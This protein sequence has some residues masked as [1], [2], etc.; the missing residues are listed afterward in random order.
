MMTTTVGAARAGLHGMQSADISHAI[1]P[2]ECEPTVSLL[3][4]FSIVW[5]KVMLFMRLEIALGQLHQVLV[6]AEFCGQRYKQEKG[7]PMGIN[8]AVF[9]ADYFLFQYDCSFM[10]R[11]ADIIMANPPVLDDMSLADD[12]FRG[13]PVASG[14][15]VWVPECPVP[16]ELLGDMARYIVG[17][18]GQV[19][20][21][22]LQLC[23]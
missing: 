9:M 2:E 15:P 1:P 19:Q 3:Q 10:Q 22:V 11:L 4:A 12:L 16:L 8:P 7:I 5:T 17:G 23:G 13:G 6:I 21:T 14:P 18:H 20:C